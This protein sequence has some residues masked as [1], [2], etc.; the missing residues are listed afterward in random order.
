[1]PYYSGAKTNAGERLTFLI[2]NNESFNSV[3]E[4][5]YKEELI[6]NVTLFKIGARLYK[7]DKKLNVGEFELRRGMSM[8]KL[9]EH[10]TNDNSKKY[11][12]YV[13]ECITNWELRK[14]LQSK[15]YL[16]NDLL[17]IELSEG[18]YAPNTYRISYNTKASSVIALM[19]AHQ[20]KIVDY[21]WKHR[22]PSLPLMSKDE[23]VVLAS[24]IEREAANLAEMPTVA[25]VFINRL[26]RNMRLQSDPTVVFG[27]DN[28]NTR[29]R[30]KI[31]KGDLKSNT[32]F[33]TY[34]I[35]G[36]PPTPICNPS[37]QAIKSAAN[38]DNTN[39]LYFVLTNS[40]T[41]AFSTSFEEHRAKVIRFRKGRQAG[42]N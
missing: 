15:N 1:M 13:K 4:R 6:L 26:N 19:R 5:F 11:D 22:H 38:P 40:G 39:F 31:L 7:L 17:G 24:I 2:Y 29:I 16:S 34:K 8:V 41:H 35:S 20:K 42:S 9:L 36:L 25:S 12:L 18:S 28:G 10:I 23:L 32:P 3:A 21:E 37:R 27:L 14:L 30:K 33:N